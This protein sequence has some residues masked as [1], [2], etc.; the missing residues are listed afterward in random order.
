MDRDC[1][2]IHYFEQPS[3]DGAESFRFRNEFASSA[4]ARQLDVL[5][6]DPF[7][8]KPFSTNPGVW[9]HTLEVAV[10]YEYDRS[11]HGLGR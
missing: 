3:L 6:D 5:A 7:S 9:D 4:D 2:L 1:K 11:S 10:D 8:P